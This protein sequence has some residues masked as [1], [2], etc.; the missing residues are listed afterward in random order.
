MSAAALASH[1][2][3]E[4]IRGDFPILET[5]VRGRRL[6]Y[7]D[8]AATS[9]KPVAVIKALREYWETSNA[10][11]HRGVHFL[12]M[13]AT[14]QFDKARETVRVFLNA[15]STQE[16]I[17]TKGCSEG[18]NLVAASLFSTASP[19]SSH[20]NGSLSPLEPGD[21]LLVSN[22][23]HHSNIVPWQL[24]AA[25]TGAIVKPIPITDQ[26]EIDQNAYDDLLGQGRVRLV[27]VNHVS[28][29]L[30]TINPIKLMSQKAHAIGA[31]VMVDGAQA[32]PHLSI[33]VQ[34]LDADFY[35]LS[36]HKI[37]APTG[38]GVLYGKKTLLEAMPPY[39]GGGDMIRTVD[40][41]GTT[42]AELPFKFEAGTPNISGVIG[43]GAAIEYLAS[44]GQGESLREKL[45]HSF[46]Q[47]S[48]HENRLARQAEDQLR[49]VSGVRIYGQAKEKASVISFTIDGVHPHDIGTFLDAEGVAVRAGHHCCMPVMTR[50]GIPAT[51]RASFALYN[52]E[53]DVEALVK[54]VSNVKEM[55]A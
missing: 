8:N 40:F 1:Y 41:S 43:L 30:G 49:Q 19:K 23:E 31:F 42:F 35:T 54:A 44:L 7:L 47:F 17:F 4:R 5:L 12:S 14:T 39:Q 9:Q 27:A 24:L 25:R 48:D 18:I 6:V 16:I 22:M 21:V 10:N 50:Y 38:I 52:T 36:C 13:K 45:V 51:A 29:S 32:G 20:G 28:N 55:F 26:G 33:D 11:V 34:D 46:A 15:S 2:D 53:A 3:V 37:Y